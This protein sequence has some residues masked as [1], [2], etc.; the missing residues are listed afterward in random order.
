MS[1]P[2]DIT[3]FRKRLFIRMMLVVCGVTGLALWTTQQ[4]VSS[5]A[6]QRLQQAF[7]DE[8]ASL[9]RTR[10][11]RHAALV[12]R[13]RSLARK[14]R[15]H[16]A[17]EDNAL[18]LLYPNAVD[19]L[20]DVM[21]VDPDHPLQARFYRFLDPAGKVIPAPPE[22][23]AGK[24]TESE[25]AKLSLARV[26]DVQQ[27][28]YLTRESGVDE[29]I[30]APIISTETHEVIA[31]IVLG[32]KAFDLNGQDP[33]LKSGIWTEG[34]LFLPNESAAGNA[35]LAVTIRATPTGSL[36][37]ASIGGEPHLV[38][39]Q[40]LNP[41]SLFPP[42]YEVSAFPM[43]EALEHQRSLRW[44]I[45]GAGTVLLLGAGF[46]SHL[47]ARRLAVPVEQLVE[48]SA[49][50]EVQREEAEAALAK[51]KAKITG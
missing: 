31:S 23:D 51:A 15:I 42:A 39:S 33:S 6:R 45:L 26:P 37:E 22:V 29:I 40:L 21:E 1:T 36:S 13:S 48:S 7:H 12:E 24:L 16:A 43:A 34:R 2:P 3:G 49:R 25:E 35:E 27:D 9:H 20:R 28:G 47:I 17:L 50:S 38:I 44:Q 30:A 8:I 4:N 41:G 18:D 14:P 19:E 5:D 11:V 32:F 10:D 46:A